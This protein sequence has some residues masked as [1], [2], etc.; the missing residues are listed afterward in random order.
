MWPTRI[1]IKITSKL[2][3]KRQFSYETC[4]FGP[5][6]HVTIMYCLYRS[7]FIYL[8]TN[9]RKESIF[10]DWC[11]QPIVQNVKYFSQWISRWKIRINRTKRVT[12][13]D[14]RTG[15]TSNDGGFNLVG[16]SRYEVSVTAV[17]Q[18]WICTQHWNKNSVLQFK[19][20]TD[21]H[22]ICHQ[23]SWRPALLLYQP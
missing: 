11:N 21:V 22:E 8:F 10:H 3:V 12:C 13:Y 19:C 18:N 14:Q 5:N 6:G 1:E 17:Y 23:Q 15:C 20:F 4:L 2:S 9:E 16:S 7:W